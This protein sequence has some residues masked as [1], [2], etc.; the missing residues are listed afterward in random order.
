MSAQLDSWCGAVTDWRVV[1]W[2]NCNFLPA[3][4][5]QL[6]REFKID[7]R[8]LGIATSS[9][10]LLQDKGINLDTWK[11]EFDT[12]VRGEGGASVCVYVRVMVCMI[13]L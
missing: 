3:Q 10:M 4:C 11:E 9:K 13:H 5:E 12:H 1:D 8:V 2:N 6:R 7:I